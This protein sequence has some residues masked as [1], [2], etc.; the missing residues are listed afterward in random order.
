MYQVDPFLLQTCQNP[1]ITDN[2]PDHQSFNLQTQRENIKDE[3]IQGYSLAAQGLAEQFPTNDDL[4]VPSFSLSAAQHPIGSAPWESYSATR[5][6]CAPLQR[7]PRAVPLCGPYM[8]KVLR[9]VLI[10]EC[11][12][13]L[14]QG[15][16]WV[17]KNCGNLFRSS[18]ARPAAAPISLRYKPQ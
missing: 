8:I 4:K 7:M 16:F 9:C 15:G 6:C 17:H 5:S 11:S 18:L 13:A 14:W 12:T 1:I 2:N 10:R 3:S